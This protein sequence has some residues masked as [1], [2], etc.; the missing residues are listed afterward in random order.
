[1]K[2]PAALAA[3]IWVASPVLTGR[4]EAWD[5]QPYYLIGLVAAG[6]AS[7]WLRP[8][9]TGRLFLALYVGQAAG[10]LAVSMFPPAS[11]DGL[12]PLGLIVLVPFT[13]I[14]WTAAVIASAARRRIR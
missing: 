14:A 11:G 9:E 2:V 6:A 4:R 3:L 13:L 10:M 12:L 8:S 1:M 5:A 7:G